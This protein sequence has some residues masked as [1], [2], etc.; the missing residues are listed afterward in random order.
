MTS[1]TWR[2]CTAVTGAP[3]RSAP[4]P[5]Q[6]PGS[7]TM[8][9]SGSSTSGIVEPGCPGC[10]PGLRP[11]EVRDER[12]A[13]LRYGGSED[14]GLLEVEESLL[15]RRS[16]STIRAVND[17]S[18]AACASIWIAC[19]EITSRSPAFAAR[20]RATNAD[21]SAAEGCDDSDTAP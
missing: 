1:V 3:V 16:N 14:G 19:V 18:C 2:R 13:G 4:Q 9:S 17:T 10:L 8:T 20:N 12:R 5:P 6:Q 21:S 7:D 15:N 11:E